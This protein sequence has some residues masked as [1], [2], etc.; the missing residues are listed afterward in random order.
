MK[1]IILSV[2]VVSFAVLSC[3]KDKTCDLNGSS[4]VGSY[5]VSSVKYKASASAPE[6]DEFATWDAC[7][8]DDVITFN[9]SNTVTFQD[10]GAVCVPPGD[11]TGIWTLV[12]NDLNID[13]QAFKVA[14]F[15]CN[16]AAI[17]IVGPGAGETYTI[18][19]ARQ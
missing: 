1:K 12:G 4:I 16:S 10:A 11:D 2:A 8:K 14:Y 7:E 13:G 3:K 9:A 19:L 18:S 5:K 6:V 15:D 17:Q